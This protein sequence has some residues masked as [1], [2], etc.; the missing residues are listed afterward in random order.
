MHA[1]LDMSMTL[2]TS[3]TSTA[4]HKSA[5]PVRRKYLLGRLARHPMRQRELESLLRK[6]A[7]VVPPD[8]LRL[9]YLDNL[10]DVDR[11][12]AGAMPSC[13]VLVEGLYGVGA[14]D[15][16]KLF[17]HVVSA[18]AGV[19]AD[20]DA[21]VFDALWAFL[22]NLFA[23]HVSPDSWSRTLEDVEASEKI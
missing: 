17:V 8:V 7:N 15:L 2:P 6:L 9:L 5:R 19:V 12:E 18:G 20:P 21:E 10:Q 1:A 22:V 3:T 13:H 11:S 23:L 16:A 14:G 4:S